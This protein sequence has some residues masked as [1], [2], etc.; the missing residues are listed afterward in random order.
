M[1]QDLYIIGA[2]SVGCHLA[3]NLEAYTS[4]YR[5]AGFLDDDPA[6]HGSLIANTPVLGPVEQI[7]ELRD[8]AV[9]LGIAFPSPKRK[10]LERLR[11]NPSLTFP[12]FISPRTW[13]SNHV[14]TG[15]GVL[16]YPGASINY[17]SHLGDFVVIN[18]NCAIGH[19]CRI[20]ALTS[21][22][23]GVNLAGHTR[24]GEAVEMGIGSATRQNVRIGDRSIIG[25][26]AMVLSDLP[27][28][29]LA[30]GLPAVI[31]RNLPNHS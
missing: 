14:T 18:M 27:H 4:Q 26:N 23:P 24:I 16:V 31:T 1:K 5:L 2:G 30:C 7:L 12:S 20:G 6:K 25:G 21:L 22:A 15:Q 8:V 19:D 3:W 29:V 11:E 9:A 13:M 28:D 10:I 17:G